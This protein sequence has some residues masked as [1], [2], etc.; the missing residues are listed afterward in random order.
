MSS[1]LESA[2]ASMI[3]N[4][5]YWIFSDHLQSSSV[6][7]EEDGDT[8]SRTTYTAFGEERKTVGPS[9]T[10]YEPMP[11]IGCAEFERC[12]NSSGDSISV[13]NSRIEFSPLNSVSCSILHH[14]P[15]Q[16]LRRADHRHVQRVQRG[17]VVP[18]TLVPAARGE[19][20]AVLR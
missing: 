11:C 10:D 7:L 16:S 14:Q 3:T 19:I 1:T 8:D 17:F 5:L 13:E 4:E 18:E 15:H 12:S 2:F 6:I 9:S 20:R